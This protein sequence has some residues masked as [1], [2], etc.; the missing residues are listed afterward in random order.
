MTSSEASSGIDMNAIISDLLKYGVIISTTLVL[1]GLVALSL[2]T[3]AA[4]PTN[5]GQLVSSGYG[6]PTLSFRALMSGVAV[7]NPLFLI[8]LG[9]IV[10]LATPV[11]RV[12]AS[13]LLFAAQ[14]DAKYV[15]I[16]LFVLG[17][18]TFSILVVGP[19]VARAG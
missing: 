19:A 12:A 3:P 18:L 2:E 5:V 1:L 10:L 14:R 11:A 7:G 6:K 9:L 16:T 8:Q 13:V 4:F 17:I 15:A